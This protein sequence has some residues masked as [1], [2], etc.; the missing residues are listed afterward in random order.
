MQFIKDIFNKVVGTQQPL[1]EQEIF[2]FVILGTIFKQDEAKYTKLYLNFDML[3]SSNSEFVFDKLTNDEFDHILIVRLHRASKSYNN[4]VGS[5]EGDFYFNISFFK[6]IQYQP[7]NDSIDE[8]SIDLIDIKG[9][10]WSVR[11]HFPKNTKQDN[12]KILNFKLYLNKLIWI[13]KTKKALPKSITEL[14]N[15]IPSKQ[16]S[17]FE[18]PIQVHQKQMNNTY[19]RVDRSILSL[20][21]TRTILDQETIGD[22][23]NYLLQQ[24]DNSIQQIYAGKLYILYTS[25]AEIRLISPLV[26]MTLNIASNTESRIELYNQDRQLLLI[27]SI[28]DLANFQVDTIENFLSWVN[29]DGQNQIVLYLKF[30]TLDGAKSMASIL[31]KSKI[32]MR[33]KQNLL[34]E[35]SSSFSQISITTINVNE[36]YNQQVQFKKQKKYIYK[37]DLSTIKGGLK[38]A[39]TKKILQNEADTLIILEDKTISFI[40]YNRTYQINQHIKFDKTYFDSNSKKLVLYIQFQYV[41]HIIDLGTETHDIIKLNFQIADVCSYEKQFILLGNQSVYVLIEGKS[42]QKINEIDQN[43]IDNYQIIRCSINGSIIIG[44]FQGLVLVFDNIQTMKQV[45]TF[46]GL[47]DLIQDIVLSTDEQFIIINNSQ[48]IQYQQ[49][50]TNHQNGYKQK[51]DMKPSPIIIQLHPEDLILMGIY[52]YPNFQHVRMDKKN[53]VIAAQFE[54]LQ[55]IW[56]VQQITHQQQNSYQIFILPEEIFDQ[57]YREEDIIILSESKIFIRECS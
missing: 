16:C 18:M 53:K 41:L 20:S 27:Q 28:K 35:T 48:Y 50:I 44:K 36:S 39:T 54:N 15:L 13:Q 30:D 51:L 43:L 3:R 24:D 52:N 47:G 25:S 11:I 32:S 46:E 1:V 31:S 19:M 49:I 45:N 42:I 34:L 29:F 33:K 2:D 55:V 22:V 7:L 26:I 23:I 14:D 12:L 56:N 40:N 4:A 37:D 9:I 10:K 8:F 38:K 57:Q 17:K 6:S 21:T 5:K